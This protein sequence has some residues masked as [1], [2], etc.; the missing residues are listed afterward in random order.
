MV[1]DLSF[2]AYILFLFLGYSC[3]SNKYKIV[4][5]GALSCFFFLVK[6]ISNYRQ[7]TMSY[8]ECKLRGV[9]KEKGYIN[10]ILDSLIDVNQTEVRYIVYTFVVMILLIDLYRLGYYL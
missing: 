4:R 6:W 7:C 1:G 10:Y 2:N 9:P 3:F 8:I 5:I